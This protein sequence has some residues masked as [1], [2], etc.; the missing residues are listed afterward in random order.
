MKV[1][2]MAKASPR[3]HT[4]ASKA[5]R[6]ANTPKSRKAKGRALQNMVRDLLMAELG[7]SRE[8]ILSRSMG[9]AGIDV[10]LSTEARSKFP[11][12]IECK[13]QEALNIWAALDQAKSNA[14]A[15]NLRPLLAFRRNHSKTYV[16][17]EFQDFINL[18]KEVSSNV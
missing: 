14:D 9:C 3:P 1:K 13:A 6:Q 17:L 10:T 18:I 7:I 11:W 8:D 2:A 15:E 4:K 12:G 5:K 16:A